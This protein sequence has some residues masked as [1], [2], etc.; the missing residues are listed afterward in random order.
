MNDEG[1]WFIQVPSLIPLIRHHMTVIR[2]F[3]AFAYYENYCNE[4]V[5]SNESD[6]QLRIERSTEWN[7]PGKQGLVDD[8]NEDF[9]CEK[10]EREKEEQE[11]N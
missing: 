1:E 6:L 2:H 3:I 4:Q 10:P 7:S 5:T 9:N 8:P 11:I